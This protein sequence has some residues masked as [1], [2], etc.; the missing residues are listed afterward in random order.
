MLKTILKS[1]FPS[2]KDRRKLTKETSKTSNYSYHANK[3][4]DDVQTIILPDLG[5][6]DKLTVTKWFAKPGDIIKS[7]DIICIL[8][9]DNMTLEFESFCSG[10]M[11][12]ACKTH[13]K[14][15]VGMEL[16]KIEKGKTS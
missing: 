12:W 1:L 16:F 4:T 10:R 15:S 9:S 7:G 11:L 14:L 6:K 5:T 3:Q 2:N 8:E 13:T